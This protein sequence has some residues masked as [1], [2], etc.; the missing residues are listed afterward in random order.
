MKKKTIIH[1]IAIVHIEDH[2]R[3]PKVV[4]FSKA[5]CVVFVDVKTEAENYVT[6]SE[7]EIRT[8]VQKEERNKTPETKMAMNVSPLVDDDE[9]VYIEGVLTS[10]KKKSKFGQFV[11]IMGNNEHRSEISKGSKEIITP[12]V[13]L[14]DGIIKTKQNVIQDHL[15]NNKLIIG[16]KTF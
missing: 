5:K 13:D 11:K 16:G 14:E 1:D 7:E 8:I 3:I 2:Q 6:I 4:Q 12:S 9:I 15:T 10:K